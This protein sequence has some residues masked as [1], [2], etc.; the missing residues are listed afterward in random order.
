MSNPSSTSNP[1]KKVVCFTMGPSSAKPAQTRLPTHGATLAGTQPKTVVQQQMKQIIMTDP[2]VSAVIREVQSEDEEPYTEDEFEDWVNLPTNSEPEELG[3]IDFEDYDNIDPEQLQPEEAGA[4][5]RKPP[6][7]EVNIN[8]IRL[9]E[10]KGA[11]IPVEIG[12]TSPAALVD[13]GAT[14]S[15]LSG[16]QYLEMGQPPFTALCKGTVRATT[17]GDM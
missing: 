3:D 15:C 7:K 12:I 6:I 2:D 14:C 4:G 10:V 16:D 17:G 13:T 9:S 1:P 8:N 5:E 11:L